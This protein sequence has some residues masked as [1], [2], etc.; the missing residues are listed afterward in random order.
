[1]SSTPL[2]VADLA[3]HYRVSEQFL[4]WLGMSDA[5]DG[6]ETRYLD[7][8]GNPM[9]TLRRTALTQPFPSGWPSGQRR[10]P[11]G[12]WTLER[13]RQRGLLFL[14]F[15]EAEAWVLWQ[16]A[17][18][19][20]ALP[21]PACLE[22]DAFPGNPS[23][24]VHRDLLLPADNL[25]ERVAVRLRQLNY[26]GRVCELRLLNGHTSLAELHR[27]DPEAFVDRVQAAFC[28]ARP[29]S[30]RPAVNAP[31]PDADYARNWPARIYL[32][33]ANEPLHPGAAALQPAP[34]PPPFNPS[35]WL[36]SLDTQL[37]LSALGR[38]RGKAQSFLQTALAA[39]P[40]PVTDLV[41]AARA[42][43][44]SPR[45]LRRAKKALGIR[46]RRQRGQAG[47]T[48][49]LWVPPDESAAKPTEAKCN[50]PTAE[51]APPSETAQSYVPPAAVG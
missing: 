48:Q 5:P 14:V 28:Q 17:Q 21:D 7:R 29:I 23:L 41:R 35:S 6:I 19:A 50:S 25:V 51:G 22:S 36:R 49:W 18:P 10:L 3:R 31:L 24:A 30:V 42:R 38:A 15:T 37:F 8:A 33:P 39:G 26:A 20:L 32:P 13:A 46:S 43:G 44:L 2:T 34:P 9:Y 11:W 45:T 27:A 47:T 16:H 4:R 40:R 12:L 1:M